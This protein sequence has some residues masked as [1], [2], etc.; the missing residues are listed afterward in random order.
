[1]IDLTEIIGAVLALMTTIITCVLIPWIQAKTTNEQRKK[2]KDIYRM[3]VFAA[4]QLVG[5]GHG[6]EKLEEAKKMIEAAGYTFD[7][8][9][10]EATVM[11]C[12]N[13]AFEETYE[14]ETEDEDEVGDAE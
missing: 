1:M 6:H 4:E 2:M 11:E 3:A 14:I 8:N 7:R 12:L 9:Q 10:L 13:L 5:A